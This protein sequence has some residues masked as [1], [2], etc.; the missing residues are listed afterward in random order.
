MNTECV[1]SSKDKPSVF[2]LSIM[3]FEELIEVVRATLIPQNLVGVIY[4]V[5]TRR[6]T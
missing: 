6:R 5:G 1:V 2:L 4:R 3:L